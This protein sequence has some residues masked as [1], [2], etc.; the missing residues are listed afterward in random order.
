MNPWIKKIGVGLVLISLV[1]TGWL[2][3]DKINYVHDVTAGNILQA[4]ATLISAIIVALLLQ[5]RMGAKSKEKEIFLE[6]YDMALNALDELG[7]SKTSDGI[8]VRAAALKKFATPC[9]T[10][11]ELITS[12]KYHSISPESLNFES[13]IAEL[14]KLTTD[15]PLNGMQ[16][17]AESCEKV[18][19]DGINQ[20]SEERDRDTETKINE[21]K[22][23][24]IKLKVSINRC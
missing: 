19:R 11:K 14:R 16:V 3:R 10:A 13:D 22:L 9:H 4:S 1:A 20:L 6:L 15:T 23:R 18:L 8:F 12:L 2:N 5:P 7:N 17:A 24:I 21:I